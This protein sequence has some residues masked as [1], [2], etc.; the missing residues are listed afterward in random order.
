MINGVETGR[1]EIPEF[2]GHLAFAVTRGRVQLRSIY[3]QQIAQAAPE[4]VYRV[5]GQ[6]LTEPSILREVKP[7]Y[8]VE[9]MRGKIEGIVALEAIVERDG[10]VGVVRVIRALDPGLDQKA[11]E[12]VRQWRFT[13][14]SREGRAVPVLVNIELTFKIK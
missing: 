13:P 1:H 4:P 3:P 14:G 9:A 6:S 5:T 10:R 11:I 2:A 12:A 8:A 7:D